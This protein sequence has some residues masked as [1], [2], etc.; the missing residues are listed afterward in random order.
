MAS[1]RPRY[2]DK[3]RASAVVMLE[4]AGYPDKKGALEQVAQ[5][6]G[7]HA[8]TLSRWFN[9]ENN[10]P[11]DIDVSKNR[12]ELSVM[13][14]S[15][16]DAIFNEMKTARAEA[17]YKDLGTVFGILVDKKQLLEGKATERTEVIDNLSDDERASR[18]AQLLDAARARRTG[19]PANS[20]WES[21]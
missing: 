9:G 19:Q 11:P 3:F 13:I 8:R 17:S 7:T 12:Q 6:T 15:E 10:P 5:A 20:E 14:A 1:K 2:D 18:I 16:I 4:A 21:T